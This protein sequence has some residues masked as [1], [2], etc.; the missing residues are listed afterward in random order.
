MSSWTHSASMFLR[1]RVERETKLIGTRERGPSC[2][3]SPEK[4]NC[5]LDSI[6]KIMKKKNRTKASASKMQEAGQENL[7]LNNKINKNKMR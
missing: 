6:K 7:L 1:E 4:S 3:G 2:P 5:R